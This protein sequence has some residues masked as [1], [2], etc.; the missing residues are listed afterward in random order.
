VALL[1]WFLWQVAVD[2]IKH[3]PVYWIGFAVRAVVCTILT[4]AWQYWLSD[5]VSK[6]FK[7]TKDIT[8][9]N[10]RGEVQLITLPVVIF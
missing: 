6:W 4:I 10:G 8:D 5:K 9:E 2:L 3:H 7:T 1:P